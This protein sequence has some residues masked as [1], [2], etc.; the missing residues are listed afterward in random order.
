MT[1]HGVGGAKSRDA[2]LG[3]VREARRFTF[4]GRDPSPLPTLPTGAWRQ[5]SPDACVANFT[6]AA[7][8]AACEV[9]ETTRAQLA[10]R[11]A[12]LLAATRA[13][14]DEAPRP[15]RM[16]STIAAVP[17]NVRLP[18]PPHALH[19]LDVLVC[20]GVLGVAE[21]G[22]IWLPAS[23]LGERAALVL[24]R[25]VVVVLSRAAI[26]ADMHAA[27]AV[28]RIADEPFGLFLAG[29]SKTADIEQSLVIGAHGATGTLVLLV[30]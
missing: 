5:T 16:L 30:E 19:D 28:L 17:G 20:E 9:E 10:S 8:A 18:Q 14:D 1:S 27:Y 22:A 15:V 24:A 29:P 6:S 3:A 11:T 7:R 23:R 12:S 21:S 4:G 2:I 25:H 13:T 26:V